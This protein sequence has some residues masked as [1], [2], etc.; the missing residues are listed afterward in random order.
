M[1][2]KQQLLLLARVDPMVLDY[3]QSCMHRRALGAAHARHTHIQGLIMQPPG[4]AGRA[5]NR[6]PRVH[7]RAAAHGRGPGHQRGGGAI[8]SPLILVQHPKAVPLVHTGPHPGLPLMAEDRGIS[9]EEVRSCPCFPLFIMPPGQ[10]P[11]ETAAPGSGVRPWDPRR[12]CVLMRCL[13][14]AGLVRRR[15]LWLHAAEAALG[16]ATRLFCC[17]PTLHASSQ[18]LLNQTSL[19]CHAGAVAGGEWRRA[20]PQWRHPRSLCAAPRRQSLLHRWAL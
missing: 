18:F 11:A 15:P 20:D 17:M 16:A 7:G 13:S 1:Q 12:L 4:V 8:I 5:E 2:I 19:R 9:V 3:K 14:L 6:V 10:I